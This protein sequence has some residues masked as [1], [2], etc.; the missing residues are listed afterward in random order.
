MFQVYEPINP[1]PS[2][3]P[4]YYF[5]IFLFFTTQSIVLT[6]LHSLDLSFSYEHLW[7]QI[8]I[9]HKNHV[10]INK[11]LFALHNKTS[12]T[13]QFRADAAA[14]WYLHKPKFFS[15]FLLCLPYHPDFVLLLVV[16]RSLSSYYFSRPH[17]CTLGGKE[18]TK[19]V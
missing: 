19:E 8:T 2:F 13:R 15:A 7:L 3:F 12:G 5:I 4:L 10:Y 18:E 11:D 14:S 16:P 9:K 1:L 17:D 6:Y